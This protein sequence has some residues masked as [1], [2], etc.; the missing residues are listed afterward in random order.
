MADTLL[1]VVDSAHSFPDLTHDQRKV[2]A[3]DLRKNAI[4]ATNLAANIG[5]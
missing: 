5:L 3:D 2:A 4:E 1:S